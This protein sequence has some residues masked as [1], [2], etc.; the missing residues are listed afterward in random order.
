MFKEIFELK[1]IEE[2][3]GGFVQLNISLSTGMFPS[4]TYVSLMRVR[5]KQTLK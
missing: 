3:L 2:K 4:V 5:R 1:K